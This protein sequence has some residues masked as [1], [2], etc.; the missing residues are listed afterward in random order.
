MTSVF[1]NALLK[2]QH[3]SI[4]LSLSILLFFTSNLIGQNFEEVQKQYFQGNYK[5]AVEEAN[6]GLRYAGRYEEDQWAELI[7]EALIADGQVK[8]AADNASQWARWDSRGIRKRWLAYETAGLIGDRS[9]QQ[10]MI[11]EMNQLARSRR[12]RYEDPENQVVLGKMALALGAD[13]K[14][15]IKN[16]FDPVV[17]QAPKTRSVYLAGGELALSKGDFAL[18]SKWFRDGMR[19]FPED[20]AM[21]SGL[22]RSFAPSDSERTL[23]LIEKSMT[24]NPKHIPSRLILVDMLLNS[25]SFD[26]V[27]KLLGEVEEIHPL[28]PKMW[29]YRAV[30][31]HLQSQTSEE[32]AARAKALEQN[33]IDPEIPYIIGKKLSQ[34]YRFKEGSAYQ[35]MALNLD[36]SYLPSK[37]QLAQDLLRLGQNEE[38]WQLASSVHEE[39]GYDVTAYNLVNLKDN[40]ADYQT[41]TN[42]HFVIHLDKKEK[43]IFGQEALE[44][45]ENAYQKLTRKYNYYPTELT[46]VEIF[47][48]TSDFE[49]RT[50]GMPNIPGYLG[51]CFGPVITA[52]SPSTAR[53][54][55]VNWK[56]VLWH[57]FCHTVTL[58]ATRNKMPRWLSEGLSVYEEYQENPA[59]GMKLTPQFLQWI[60]DGDLLPV[61]DLSSGFMRP[62]TPGHIEFAYYQSSMVVEYLLKK[63]PEKK[64]ADLLNDLS[65]G[66]DINAA[67][68]KNYSSIDELDSQ[69][70]KWIKNIVNKSK[71]N[72]T[73]TKAAPQSPAQMLQTYQ[74]GENGDL[75]PKDSE[76]SAN[77]YWKKLAQA[78]SLLSEKKYKET[79]DL[80]ESILKE[81]PEPRES[82]NP[83]FI[84]SSVYREQDDFKMEKET[85]EKWAALEVVPPDIYRRLL[86]FSI[87]EEENEDIRKYAAELIAIDPFD[88]DPYQSLAYVAETEKSFPE[89]I[90]NLELILKLDPLNPADIHYKLFKL[91]KDPSPDLAYQNLLSTLELAPRHKMALQDFTLIRQQILKSDNESPKKKPETQ[92]D[93]SN[94]SEN[95]KNANEG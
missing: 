41:V 49:V 21:T 92:V 93:E 44:L 48:S 37:I 32:A 89:A 65:R 74:I 55:S 59:W 51:V 4:Y 43:E 5:K 16:F 15:V 30:V 80:I 19:Q 76:D 40:L 29:A 8:T 61:S 56:A 20:P 84:L 2:Q 11:S 72:L 31:Y 34:Q 46:H 58:G 50:F 87:E 52:N 57:E 7:V 14:L 88:V 54:N 18:A 85:L 82:P 3:T 81:F 86:K 17:K 12:S 22:A 28:E 23:E 1:S 71:G 64:M 66:I 42:E 70:E 36:Q 38:G 79:Q 63:Y 33:S 60:Q 78:Q 62:K 91:R 94:D 35:R 77:N 13:P 53:M 25:E 68:E 83:L 90:K 67:L 75:S 10:M 24:L 39:D 47:A 27:N 9:M 45:L 69:F 6:E 26:D 95:I 73:F